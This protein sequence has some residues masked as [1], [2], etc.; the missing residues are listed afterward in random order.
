MDAYGIGVAV[1]SAREPHAAVG[2]AA[3]GALAQFLPADL[4][5]ERLQVR[6]LLVMSARRHVAQSPLAIHILI[7][8]R[9]RI[10][11]AR[12]VNAHALNTQVHRCTSRLSTEHYY[13]YGCDPHASNTRTCAALSIANDLRERNILTIDKRSFRTFVSRHSLRSVLCFPI[14]RG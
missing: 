5:R 2:A 1:G 7:H 14:F 12:G 8:I 9:I 4:P 10:D 3:E 13:Y 11:K 6:L